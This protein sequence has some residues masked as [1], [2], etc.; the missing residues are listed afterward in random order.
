VEAIPFVAP[1]AAGAL[2]VGAA[3]IVGVTLLA[4]DD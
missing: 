3:F 1:S 2:V 4:D